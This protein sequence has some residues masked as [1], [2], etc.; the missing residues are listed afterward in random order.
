MCM[1]FRQMTTAHNSVWLL[2]MLT[3]LQGNPAVHEV[4]DVRYDDSDNVT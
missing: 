4:D 1:S 2:Y 3:E